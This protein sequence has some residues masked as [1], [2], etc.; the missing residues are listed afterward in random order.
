M[1]VESGYN[2]V[3]VSM[4]MVLR[5]IG[6]PS[7]TILVR[8]CVSLCCF[9]S[10]SFRSVFTSFSRSLKLTAHPQAVSRLRLSGDMPL[11]P[12]Y[13]VRVFVETTSC[14][15]SSSKF[16]IYPIF[17]HEVSDLRHCYTCADAKRHVLR[18]EQ[19]DRSPYRPIS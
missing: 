2:V 12:L 5:I 7:Y 1:Y 6:S 17:Q 10:F 18:S 8:S 4:R 14:L 11:L 9:F 19:G 13:A 15:F 16:P 3:R